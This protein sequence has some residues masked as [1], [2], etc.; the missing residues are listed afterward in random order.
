MGF[1]SVYHLT[2][3]PSILSGESLVIFD[4]HTTYVP[5]ATLSQPGLRLRF[6]G[7]S[8]KSTFPDQFSPY[9]FFGCNMYD[10]YPGTLFRFPLRDQVA[11]RKS[12]ISKRSYSLSDVDGL[13]S[14]LS[15]QLANHLLFLR[16][17]STIELYRCAAGERTPTLI[18][19]AH[20]IISNKEVTKDQ[21]LMRYFD[22]KS[23]S[24][25]TKNEIFSRDNFYDALLAIKDEDLP[26]TMCTV[27]IDVRDES[28][29]LLE[30]VEYLVVSGLRGGSAKLSACDPGRRH[31]KLVPFGGVAVCVSKVSV[32]PESSTTAG[33][34]ACL[35]SKCRESTQF[36]PIQGQAFCFLP[37]PVKTK[38]PIHVNAYFELSSNR[39]DI[40]KADDTV[41]DSRVRGLWNDSL[42][43][44]V[45][46]P[47]YATLIGK[48]KSKYFSSHSVGEDAE[49][50]FDPLKLL[51][52][53]PCP[54]PQDNCW[55]IICTALFPLLKAE[56]IMWCRGERA[57]IPLSDSIII[58]S[59]ADDNKSSSA[60]STASDMVQLERLLIEEM[61]PIVSV[62][63]YIFQDLIHSGC[64]RD[65]VSPLVVR[66]HF[67]NL[68]NG[69]SHPSV[70]FFS[71]LSTNQDEKSDEKHTNVIQKKRNAAFLLS[72]CISDLQASLCSP[73]SAE[74]DEAAA[75]L[76]GL[77]LVPT[78]GGQQHAML[79]TPTDQPLY[80]CSE[81]ERRLLLSATRNIIAGPEIIGLNLFQLFSNRAFAGHFNVSSLSPVD[82][83]KLLRQVL[84]S[85]WFWENT[86]VVSRPDIVT[87][88]WLR[89]VW[90]YIIGSNACEIFEGSL[91]L[92]PVFVAGQ[93][94]GSQLLKLKSGVPMLHMMFR[95]NMSSVVMECLGS[96][97]LYVY[98]PTLL[99]GL[100]FS[101]EL[102]RLLC[103]ATNH[104]FVEALVKV[105]DKSIQSSNSDMWSAEGKE[106]VRNY[107]LDAILP[108]CDDLSAREQ[109]VL[110][111][112]GIWRSTTGCEPRPLSGGDAICDICLPP[113]LFMMPHYTA[114]VDKL[115]TS[116]SFVALRCESDR[117][118]YKKMGV[119]EPSG[120]NYIF[121]IVLPTL[122]SDFNNFDKSLL[123]AISLDILSRLN[124]LE[125][126]CTGLSEKLKNAQFVK[127]GAGGYS[128]PSALYDPTVPHMTSLLPDD[129]F[130]SCELYGN[131]SNVFASL[132]SLGMKVK[133]TCDGVL[134]AAEAIH[135][136]NISE[137]TDGAA[138]FALLR[139][140]ELLKYMDNNVESLLSES[141][142][143]F[144]RRWV[145][146]TNQS[147]SGEALKKAR[148]DDSD[149]EID[150][151]S[152]FRSGRLGG[153]KWGDKMRSLQWVP[154]LTSPGS[155]HAWDKHLP[156][157][158]SLHRLHHASGISSVLPKNRWLCS[159]THR[160]LEQEVQ[161]PLL[162]TLMGWDKLV[163]GNSTAQQ[164]LFFV[165]S[166][167]TIL[168]SGGGMG[169]RAATFEYL[170]T[171]VPRLYEAL[172]AAMESEQP[173]IIEI[174]ARALKNKPV[175]WIGSQFV[176]PSRVAFEGLS[177]I[178][179]EPFL[180]TVKGE[181]IN[182]SVFL[183]A[184]GVRDRF[185]VSDI[186]NILREL[187]S[188][189]LDIPLP[190]TKLDMCVGLVNILVRLTN[191]RAVALREAIQPLPVAMAVRADD[192]DQSFIGSEQK[193]HG[194][195]HNEDGDPTHVDFSDD[196][197]WKTALNELGVLFIP[198]SSC[199]LAPTQAL[200]FDDAPW[201]SGA[202][203]K[204]AV[205]SPQGKMQFRF[206]SKR[207]DNNMAKL[208]GVKSLREQFFAGDDVVC[209]SASDIKSLLAGDSCVDALGDLLGVADELEAE[210]VHVMID[211]TTYPSESLI[212][213]GLLWHQQGPALIVYY[214]GIKFESE[215]LSQMFASTQC[216]PNLPYLCKIGAKTDYDG[217]VKKRSSL[218]S[219]IKG[220]DE[221]PLDYLLPR[222]GK[223]LASAFSFTDCLQILS[224][225]YLYIY[226]PTG[227]YIFGTHNHGTN[228]A[229]PVAAFRYPE[230][231]RAQR[232]KFTGK[233]GADFQA[234]FPDQ[235]SPYLN[236]K[237]GHHSP[238]WNGGSLKG[239]VLRMPLRVSK[240]S[241]SDQVFTDQTI[242]DLSLHRARPIL[243]GLL[244]FGLHV[245]RGSALLLPRGPVSTRQ[246]ELLIS[247]ELISASASRK[248]MK[249]FLS[250]NAWK[251]SSS[252]LGFSLFKSYVPA[253]DDYR[254]GIFIRERKYQD[255][256]DSTSD[257]F[258]SGRLETSNILELQD[259]WLV[260]L[261]MGQARLRDLVN[262][263]PFADLNLIPF[264]SLA[265]KI[266]L[267]VADE[268]PCHP[269]NSGYF[270]CGGCSM[271]LSGLP[272]HLSGTFLQDP[273]ERGIPLPRVGGGDNGTKVPSRA[274]PVSALSNR[275]SSRA[276][277]RQSLHEWN[278]AS[279]KVAMEL[280][281]PKGLIEIVSLLANQNASIKERNLLFIYRQ[282]P[283]LPRAKPY[284][285][286]IVRDVKLLPLLSKKPLFLCRGE[287]LTL[288]HIVL[289]Y[290][291]FPLP[292]LK[293]LQSFINLS[294]VP[295]QIAKDMILCQVKFNSLSPAK[296]REFIKPDRQRHCMKLKNQYHILLPILRYV[297]SDL[298]RFSTHG[299]SVQRYNFDFK[300]SYYL[301]CCCY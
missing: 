48:V 239:T 169:D 180:Y 1:N 254:V 215:M 166:Y 264:I 167:Q 86:A 225:D 66:S 267:P 150:D 186:S 141:D 211:C 145:R 126:D 234:G 44:E 297:I 278:T 255:E 101:P 220:P 89:D 284:I 189:F 57:F 82:V 7:S 162:S 245:K 152:S 4:P 262:R 99:G 178:D 205:V 273:Q 27:R 195:I 94:D 132:R 19:R 292:V 147:F 279:L 184:I 41:G 223:R 51:S 38:L 139:S 229:T 25:E 49:I 247:M 196:I 193:E 73:N 112:M 5:G 30:D 108:R 208:L 241:I 138:R 157:P 256:G 194:E 63:S 122:A 301:M 117:A 149:D 37:L 34:I 109:E 299:D 232:C 110:R 137:G 129:A 135:N 176:E 115:Q 212:H 286:E 106:T 230:R 91:P 43:R 116:D 277:S 90:S 97:G 259:D 72:Y 272:F 9:A 24:T 46:A 265:I 171:T 300:I 60:S 200:C 20:S 285:S 78:D 14:N 160:I 214:D 183:K 123:D 248:A 146:R 68:R 71:Y 226:D 140:R 95:E 154:V 100:S 291:E 39:R 18:K 144:L 2:D 21:T 88:E 47:L 23:T 206:V 50:A 283:Y 170:F 260:L 281:C 64:V 227:N 118:L 172:V 32:D 102:S 104:G 295:P 238:V 40:W 158:S 81:V 289:S 236:L 120:G 107:L 294:E 136:S 105:G 45:I 80:I 258:G 221:T 270:F 275:A 202:L 233:E 17:V 298:N 96:V 240:S 33:G 218:S 35:E 276:L 198:D 130:P 15:A 83:L 84:P 148:G 59:T 174:W 36:P 179:T 293:Y 185:D 177:S 257:A 251:K 114:V 207:F 133:L 131:D 228:G 182:Y 274:T 164:L 192:G 52:L 103:P 67:K 13:L 191:E 252:M 22:R 42:M 246:E 6:Q 93:S 290:S 168:S 69:I 92:L 201:I 113:T 250:D 280:L 151:T 58:S 237:F 156:W 173:K 62:P 216:V 197:H 55:Q 213:P 203:Y 85:E 3:T 153:G 181:L 271:G 70:D 61:L 75:A 11:A 56:E 224:G 28:N 98:N 8:M 187:H 119:N 29:T 204:R 26:T 222:C 163:P 219:G 134:R 244:L 288:D 31:L 269:S 74:A 282:W 268:E 175:V 253:E 263:T 125:T 87:D 143:D 235:L 165:D 159:C 65:H 53:L 242:L 161:S 210:G 124:Q 287:F 16:S 188:Q 77:P 217:D 121:Y 111:D 190:N 296:L 127:N 249:Q 76:F 12:E 142:P 10:S 266:S 261:S 54:V 243:E 155:V 209:P 128:N 231:Q 199:I 79:Q